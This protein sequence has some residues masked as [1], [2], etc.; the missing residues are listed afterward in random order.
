[1][2]G[3]VGRGVPWFLLCQE[4]LI[5]A[6]PA[7]PPEVLPLEEGVGGLGG[8]GFYLLAAALALGNTSPTLMAEMEG[9]TS[10]SPSPLALIPGRRK[11]W[12]GEAGW[13]FC[14]EKE[15]ERGGGGCFCTHG[16]GDGW[17][18]VLCPVQ[19]TVLRM[20]PVCKFGGGG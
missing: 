1:M 14:M 10:L 9:W 12:Q 7:R 5:L 17:D 3:I 16:S 19:L 20:K 6:L 18:T 11:V 13:V 2:D 15:E 8:V 4:E